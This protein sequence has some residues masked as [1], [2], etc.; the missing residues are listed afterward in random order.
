VRTHNQ[1]GN[2]SNN[3]AS[4]EEKFCRKEWKKVTVIIISAVILILFPFT[5]GRYFAS[6]LKDFSMLDRASGLARLIL[7]PWLPIV[8]GL[9]PLGLLVA[10]F[11]KRLDMEL[12]QKLLWGAMLFGIVAVVLFALSLQSTPLN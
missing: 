10:A 4:T 2:V 8:C 1:E 3:Q 7:I 9:V 5:V 12:R 11:Q 6:M